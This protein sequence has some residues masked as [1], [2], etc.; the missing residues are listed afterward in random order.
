MRHEGS[1]Q[2]LYRE[3]KIV[4]LGKEGYEELEK[5]GRSIVKRTDAIICCMQLLNA[6]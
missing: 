1:K 4:Q 5:R 2:G 3:K 6:I